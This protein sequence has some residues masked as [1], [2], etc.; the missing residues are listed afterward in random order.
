MNAQHRSQI[1]RKRFGVRALLR[2]FHFLQRPTVVSTLVFLSLIAPL[3]N[4]STQN[5]PALTGS[6]AGTNLRNA[7]AATQTQ[8]NVL[9]VAS[10]NW[11]RR[12]GS[13]NYNQDQ[14]HQDFNNV[15]A[16]FQ[17]LRTQFNWLA[18]LALQLGRAR[19]NNAV[20]ELDAG[21]N[22]IAELF[23]FLQEQDA[24]GALD[25][26]TVVRTARAF[27]QA[28]QEWDREFRKSSSRLQLAF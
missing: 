10:D 1:A 4:A 2:R 24:A 12:A 19:A 9:L 7:A 15:Q 5:P 11:Q 22:I 20:A 6:T 3:Q 26:A 25:R 16:Q 28:I 18:E 14:F 23:V 13:A 27:H 17:A 8:L 21:L